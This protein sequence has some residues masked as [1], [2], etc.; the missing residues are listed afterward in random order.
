MPPRLYHDAKNPGALAVD[1]PFYRRLAETAGRT[2]AERIAVPI[3]TGRA[4]TVRKGQICRVVAVE[5][6]QVCDFNAW[7]LHNAWSQKSRLG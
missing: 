1:R 2:L 6:P 7:N 5:G 3:R 4:W